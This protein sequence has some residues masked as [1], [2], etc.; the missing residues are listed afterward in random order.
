MSNLY[1]QQLTTPEVGLAILHRL[2]AIRSG[3]AT[4]PTLS[5][6]S[7]Q[8]STD[9]TAQTM[10]GGSV[11]SEWQCLYCGEIHQGDGKSEANC[12]KCGK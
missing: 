1:R 10:P 8:V 11:L 4:I 9:A 5:S 6:D 2:Q 7:P 3:S 12:P